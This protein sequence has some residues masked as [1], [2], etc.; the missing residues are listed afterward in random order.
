MKH[1]LLVTA[2]L[3]AAL[4]IGILAGCSVTKEEVLTPAP[5]PPA[6][7]TTSPT[8][9]PAPT[10]TVAPSPTA[11]PPTPTAQ[12]TPPPPTETPAVTG[13]VPQNVPEE[14]IGQWAGSVDDISL[15]FYVD[16]DGTGR[17]SFEQ[18]GYSE[19][20]DFMLEV[21]T[22][23]FSVNIPS[24]NQLGITAIEGTYSYSGGTLTLNV[25]TS[26]SGGNVFRYTVPCQ[27]T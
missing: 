11:T 20:Y 24:N 3:F 19:S 5:T 7:P 15:S 4:F 17:Y 21:G 18:G 9:T 25:R 10:P 16:A 14:Y 23:T 26:F 12:P 6:T 27:K 2:L 1:N 8:A 22:E 13:D